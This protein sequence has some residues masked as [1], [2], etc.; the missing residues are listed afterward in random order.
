M[1]S[2][3]PFEYPARLIE[4]ARRNRPQGVALA[5]ADSTLALESVRQAF[6]LKIAVPRLIGDPD[7]IA[8]AAEKIGWHIEGVEI[9]PAADEAAAAQAAVALA[10][11]GEVDLLMKGSVHTDVLMRAVVNRDTGLR[12]GRRLSHVFHMTMPGSDRVLFVTDAALNVAPDVETRLAILRNAVDLARALGNSE[13]KAA[14]L[15]ATESVIASMPSSLEADE[16]KRR[17]QGGEIKHAIVDGPFALDLVVSPD[18]AAV[19]GVAN[20]VAGMADIVLV[21]NIETGNAL[22]KSMVY[23][24]S[25]LAAGIVL[26]AK[27]PIVL[28][29]R[30]DPPEARLAA[31][32]L[33]APAAAV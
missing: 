33:A 27:V 16:I 11:A 17:A 19:K 24:R 4:A 28:T 31:L 8:A 30:A 15:S 9:V 23:F 13:P 1:L 5:G 7:R 12:T 22:F 6:E 21:P 29:S 32:A 3:V 20:R 26:G 2:Q 25:A 10:R 18:A 14:V